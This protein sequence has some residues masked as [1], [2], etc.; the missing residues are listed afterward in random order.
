MHFLVVP[1]YFMIFWEK[2]TKEG[3]EGDIFIHL[4]G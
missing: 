1:F 2:Q 3:V 4:T